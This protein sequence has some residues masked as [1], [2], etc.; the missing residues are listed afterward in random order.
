[1][2]RRQRP[3]QGIQKAVVA[4][5]KARG[6]TGMVFLHVPNGGARSAIEGA[7]FKSLGVIPGAPDLLLW[8][9]GKSYAIELKAEDGKVTDAQVAVLN[10]LS[11]AGV[12]TS[13]CHGVD[14]A[15]ACLE[16]WGLLKGRASLPAHVS[17][18]MGGRTADDD[19][20]V[21]WAKPFTD[22]QKAD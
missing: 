20:N 4:H 9:D 11:A 19:W 10:R 15:I 1:M 14:R 6:T 12:Y 16:T 2:G 3:E 22:T 21:M 17:Y 13:I 18:L 5:L 8:H 7:I